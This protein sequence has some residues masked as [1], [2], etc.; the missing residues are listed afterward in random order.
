MT[1]QDLHSQQQSA[2]EFLLWQFLI[3]SEHKDYL[4]SLLKQFFLGSLHGVCISNQSLGDA[5]IGW[6]P[7]F[8]NS[9]LRWS[10]YSLV[11]MDHTTPYGLTP[12]QH[13][14]F[15]AWPL[16]EIR[17]IIPVVYLIWTFLEN[18]RPGHPQSKLLLLFTHQ[19]VSDSLWPHELR[20]AKLP[21]PSLSP[22]VCLNSCPLSQWCHPTILP[23]VAPFSSCTQSFP[24]SGSFPMS[25]LFPI[26]WPK[27]WNIS[28]SISSS[29]EYSGFISFRF[30]WF[31]PL[32]VQGTLKSL[33]QH[34]SWHSAFFMV[35][36]LTSIHNYWK[37]H[38][39]D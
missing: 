3:F 14:L 18:L 11:P 21:W 39:F 12:N 27:Y 25:Q 35:Q 22:G 36:L 4:G 10:F 31:D 7:H 32:A 5:D 34:H 9:C 23:S 15:V 1:T 6:G 13:H 38:S 8:K 20:H 24:A 29:N 33:F 17:F 2:R 26:R 28:F 16:Q 30:D 37:N 19:V